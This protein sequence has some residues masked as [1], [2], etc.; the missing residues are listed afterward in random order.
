M[1]AIPTTSDLI[2]RARRNVRYLRPDIDTSQEGIATRAHFFPAAQVASLVFKLLDRVQDIQILEN[3]SDADV[4]AEA[5]NYG[6]IRGSGKRAKTT[7]VFFTYTAPVDDIR[8][9]AGTIVTTS[10]VSLGK[11]VAFR[12]LATRTLPGGVSAEAFF[13]RD[14]SR[15]ETDPIPVEAVDPGTSGIVGEGRITIVQAAITGI[16]GV[17][18]RSASSGGT[19]RETTAQLRARISRKRLGAERNLRRGLE[20]FVADNYAFDDANAVR[21]DD[22]DSERSDGVDVWVIDDSTSETEEVFAHYSTVDLYA[23]SFGPML[24]VSAVTGTSA[25]LL[26]QGADYQVERDVTTYSRLST[27]ASDRIRLT[28]AGHTKLAQG[29]VI[30]VVYSYANAV[31]DAQEALEQD[32]VAMLTADPLVKRAIRWDF[33]IRAAVTF[34][35]GVDQNV[36]RQRVQL[37]LA[38]FGSALNLGGPVQESD[39]V[40]TIETGV[41]G[42]AI[43]SVDQVVIRD[44]TATSELGEVRRLSDDPIGQTITMGPHEY[45]R[46]ASIAF[47]SPS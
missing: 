23:L 8:I 44:V 7:V 34:F 12:T 19:D 36:E 13:R 2:E 21:P 31:H 1:V 47:V 16:D 40:V 28:P 33:T 14:V 3:Q 9:P 18:N 15:W 46:F 25:G 38:Q 32:D 6:L 26:T 11:V 22:G 42:V 24:L 27:R 41:A 45:A 39:L 20:A 43:Q 30:T 4:D 17:L 35:A 29:E 10:T 37:A 5:T